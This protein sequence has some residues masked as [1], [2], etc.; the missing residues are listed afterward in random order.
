VDEAGVIETV[1]QT[2]QT[3]HARG[4]GALMSEQWRL[5]S[6]LRVVRREV[7][8][9]RNSKILPLRPLARP[10]AGAAVKEASS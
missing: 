3:S 4:G 6:N 9:T 1:L 2:L 10:E 5:G 8:T 7:E